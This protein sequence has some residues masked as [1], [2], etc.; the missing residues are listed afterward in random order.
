MSLV[1]N[2]QDRWREH[3]RVVY[4][5]TRISIVE[6]PAVKR[7]R[8]ARLLK[9]YA[10]FATYY[11]PHYISS[12]CGDFQIEAANK[13][14]RDNNIMA[15]LEWPREHAKSVH[16]GVIIPL[17]LKALGELKGMVVVGKNET[18]GC[19]MLGRPQAELEYNQLYIED[20]GPQHQHGNWEEGEFETTDMVLFKSYG[21]GQSP[22]GLLNR[23]RRPNYCLVDDIDDDVIVLN[24]DR[25]D[26][27]VKWILGSLYG[28]LAIKQS[29]LI[30]VGNRIHP[31]SILAH[32]V[33]DTD[34]TK[35]KRPGIFHSKV[36]ATVDGTFTGKPSW[37]QNFT[38]EQLQLR[39]QRMGYYLAM[40][41]YFHQPVIVGKIF[42]NDW[43]HWG[44]IPKL[45]EM[46][47]IVAYFDPS[48][49][50]KTTND[51]KA[52][53]VWGKKGINL[54]CIDAFVKQATI[55]EA[56]KW[57]YDFHESLPDNVI[58]DYYMEEVFLQDMF[59]ED[60]ENE[61]RSR[62]YFLPVRGDKRSKPD[63]FARIQAISPL[64]ER[65]LVLYNI[66]KKNSSHMITGID[67]L[68]A[69][70]KGARIHDDSPDADEGALWILQ[71]RGRVD[72]FE[73]VIGNR[74][75]P[76]LW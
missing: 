12:P 63:K 1:S 60:F 8:I 68:L 25:V 65:G 72:S 50:S 69:F 14:R 3:C 74:I 29:R 16:A 24:P 53:K 37:H 2:A 57:L 13:I 71:R 18:D 43:I 58:V 4:D 35:T 21:R 73:P 41:E 56:V 7:Q 75:H 42:K 36:Y 64:W 32:I 45:S 34:D 6:V 48:Y 76:N 15:V 67:Q 33:G 26:E 70:Q 9:N 61:A 30:I 5:A 46:D 11:F 66:A 27:A 47:N 17:W 23:E 28:S 20:F 10:D 19:T 22:R 62:G 59:Y 54:Y 38:S 55:T 52:I 31:K 51:F 49:K 40:R 44:K 39:F